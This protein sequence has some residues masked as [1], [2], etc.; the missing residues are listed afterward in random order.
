MQGKLSQSA[1][2]GPLQKVT[3][4]AHSW[5][6]SIITPTEILAHLETRTGVFMTTLLV[7]AKANKHTT[8]NHKQLNL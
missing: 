1:G 5:W 3:E 4:H 8:K 2:G 7:T 6:F